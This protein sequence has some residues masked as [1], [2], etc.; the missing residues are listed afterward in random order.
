M[1]VPFLLN[2][3]YILLLLLLLKLPDKVASHQF[4]VVL[5]RQLVVSLHTTQKLGTTASA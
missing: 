4:E 2:F 5:L 1:I 3:Y